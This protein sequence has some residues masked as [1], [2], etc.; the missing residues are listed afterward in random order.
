MASFTRTVDAEELLAQTSWV[1]ALVRRLVVDEGQ[2]EDLLQDTW[3]AALERPAD[4]DR[5]G[6]LRAW[7]AAVARNLA[8]RRRRREAVRVAIERAAARPEPIE[9]G[10]GEVER[11]QLQRVLVDAVLA[12][13]EPYRAAVILR[14][15]DGLS[16]AEIAR[17]QGCSSAAARQRISRGLAQLRARLADR[18]GREGNGCLAL[19]PLLGR[20]WSAGVMAGGAV[21]S[22]KLIVGA[23]CAALAA[24]ALWLATSGNG[25]RTA[26]GDAVTASDVLASSQAAGELPHGESYALDAPASVPEVAPED[27]RRVELERDPASAGKSAVRGRITDTSGRPLDNAVLRLGHEGEVLEITSNDDGEVTA[28][29]DLALLAAPRTVHASCEGYVPREQELDLGVPFVI[30]LEALPA[31]AGRVL[32]PAGRPVAQPGYVRAQVL[33]AVTRESRTS[34]TE[35][36]ADGTYRL[37]RLPVGRLVSVEARARGFG[38]SR[39]PMDRALEADRTLALD[40]AVE[41]GALVT[42]IVRDARTSEPV[43]GALVWMETFTPELG[44][45]HPVTTTDEDG[46]FRIEGATGELRFERGMRMAF[47]SIVARADGY[48]SSPIKVYG[49][50]ANPDH[51][52]IFELLLAPAGCSLRVEAKLADGRPAR[53]ATVWGI[54]ALSNPFF[55]T[56]DENGVY[57]FEG[58][59][60]GKFGV[61]ILFEDERRVPLAGS[62][63]TVTMKLGRHALRK[64]LELAPDEARVEK[65]VL[66]PPG[67]ASLEGRVVDGEG[68]GVPAFDVRAQLNFQLGSLMLCSGWDEALTDEDG[69]YRFADLH[70]GKYQVWA[71]GEGTATACTLPQSTYVQVERDQRTEVE[72]LLVG[73]CMTIE[74]RIEGGGNELEAMELVALDPASGDEIAKAMPEADG[75]FRFEPLVARDYEVVLFGRGEALDRAAIGPATASGVFL[76]AR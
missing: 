76:R 56:A 42:G 10:I 17:R 25:G 64:E 73:A 22:T 2:V 11:M 48:A 12:L 75:S 57:Q 46:R 18:F 51:P 49:A 31:L 59:P 19:V 38:A 60:A 63:R 3:V 16:A 5:N 8:L 45:V 41:R 35:I 20:D 32:D 14:H 36:A 61:W 40:L 33:D 29:L 28:E 66:L 68:R 7:L 30:P 74:G 53:G 50:E 27:A 13:D 58:L 44:S 34:E 1:R 67:G 9:G 65:L 70:A 71:S 6:G 26:A 47:F 37:E 39:T 55:E 62:D 54:D 72:D 4:G 52:F 24:L 23:A 21:V 43:P 69:R 15:L